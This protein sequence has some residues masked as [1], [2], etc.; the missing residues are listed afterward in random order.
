VH[1]VLFDP[2]YGDQPTWSLSTPAPY[3]VSEA[4]AQGLLTD[5]APSF[6]G[7][8]SVIP[9][10]GAAAI[11]I[12]EMVRRDPTAPWLGV[13][14]GKV[15]LDAGDARAR[16]VLERAAATESTDF[17]ETFRVA[18]TIERLS[19]QMGDLAARAYER[20]YTSFIRHFRDPRLMTSLASLGTM[21][22]AGGAAG[23]PADPMLRQRQEHVFRLAPSIDGGA[24][25][26]AHIGAYWEG[27]GDAQAAR[28]WRK[29]AE[30]ARRDRL[31]LATEDTRV[32][33]DR[34]WLAMAASV[35]AWCILVAAIVRRYAARRRRDRGGRRGIP[36]PLLNLAYASGQE[37]AALLAVSAVGWMSVSLLAVYAHAI[38][39]SAAEPLHLGEIA[40][41]DDIE[42][43]RER[44][45]ASPERDLLLAIAH[46]TTGDLTEAERRYR[47]LPQFAVS[48]NNLGVILA[49]TRRADEAQQAFQRALALS[50]TLAEATLNTGGLPKSFEAEMHQQYAPVRKMIALP[51]REHLL[52]AHLGREWTDRYRAMWRGPLGDFLRTGLRWRVEAATWLGRARLLSVA[53]A[54]LALAICVV[55]PLVRSV[56]PMAMPLPVIERVVPGLSPAWGWAGGPMLLAWCALLLAL[57]TSIGWTPAVFAQPA[58]PDVIG[59]FGLLPAGAGAAE[60]SS[61]A[62]LGVAAVAI[63]AGNVALLRRRG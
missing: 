41:P 48:W 37:R 16:D 42:Y 11:P 3:L 22:P 47:Q 51:D 25:A 18:G 29:R 43:F 40:G 38:E 45:P 6:T 55:A 46:H 44:L 8:F 19:D 10:A 54:I 28:I 21:Y 53:M 1:T 12:E 35:L 7:W 20:A 15:L 32:A 17:H 63:W 60:G 5:V 36:L 2:T 9:N 52:R 27:R 49:R 30:D 56:P 13:A 57:V 34:V 59:A 14:L 24:R 61:L 39:R 62:P 50:P 26:W 33:H 58:Q 4:E 31:T 23:A